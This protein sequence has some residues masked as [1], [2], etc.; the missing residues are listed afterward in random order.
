MQ[1]LVI[2]ERGREPEGGEKSRKQKTSAKPRQSEAVGID[3]IRREFLF[4]LTWYVYRK[5]RKGK[6]H[7]TTDCG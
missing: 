1:K 3:K 6:K 5:L 7:T 4:F 2:K